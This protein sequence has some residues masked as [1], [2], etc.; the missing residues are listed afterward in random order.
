[1]KRRELRKLSPTCNFSPVG[2]IPH[3]LSVSAGGVIISL[4]ELGTTLRLS[5]SLSEDVHGH[6][7]SALP[8]EPGARDSQA[9]LDSSL[10]PH[11]I[12]GNKVDFIKEL[13]LIALLF[14]DIFII[15]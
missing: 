6:D 1:M 7:M 12:C 15:N 13:L 14:Y 11:F 10:I 4:I 5:E 2:E 8:T 3:H 9:S